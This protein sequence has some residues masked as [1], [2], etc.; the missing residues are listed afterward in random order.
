MCDIYWSFF[1]FFLKKKSVFDSMGRQKKQARRGVTYKLV[2]LPRGDDDIVF[3]EE[4]ERTEFVVTSAD[5]DPVKTELVPEAALRS[6]TYHVERANVR[7]NQFSSSPRKCAAEENHWNNEGER[8]EEEMEKWEREGRSTKVMKKDE[9]EEREGEWESAKQDDGRGMIKGK[10]YDSDGLQDGNVFGCPVDTHPSGRRSKDPNL[11]STHPGRKEDNDIL[12]G[13]ED[14][15]DEPLFENAVEGGVTDDFLRQ[16]VLG[17]ERRGRGGGGE[18][19]HHHHPFSLSPDDE[20]RYSEGDWDEG[21]GEEYDEEE[22]G[23]EEDDEMDWDAAPLD[24]E[25]EGE[26][27]EQKMPPGMDGEVWRLLSEEEREGIL[28][29]DPFHSIQRKMGARGDS[30]L[31]SPPT[32]SHPMRSEKH[33][34]RHETRSRL[35]DRQFTEMLHEFHVDSAINDV[36]NVNDPRTQGPLSV[37][38]YL[39]ALQ[40]FVAERAGLNF[41]TAELAKNKGLMQ[42]LRLLQHREGAFGIDFRDGGIYMPSV[43]SQK[44]TNFAE[45][46]ADETEAIRAAAA[47]R[48]KKTKHVLSTRKEELSSHVLSIAGQESVSDPIVLHETSADRSEMIHIDTDHHNTMPENAGFEVVTLRPREKGKRQD[49]ETVL[50]TYSAYYNQPNV[51]RPSTSR[52]RLTNAPAV[53]TENGQSSKDVAKSRCY[54]NSIDSCSSGSAVAPTPMKSDHYSPLE[55]ASQLEQ[56]EAGSKEERNLRKKIFKAQQRQRRQEKSDLKKAYKNVESEEL[57]RISMSTNA[58]KTVHFS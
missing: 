8:E 16:L 35:I 52:S 21:M 32:H 4:E 48:V 22:W 31:P 11:E 41:E 5:T 20:E 43:R 26:K 13:E 55:L 56:V 1:F 7:R 24:E 47:A 18:C 54:P 50:S 39:P 27:R 6:H 9:M 30:F 57:K 45:S 38:Q 37:H 2:Q 51:I 58:K 12:T 23:V 14:E 3:D 33:Y 40:E 15:E 29:A 46:F 10:T 34:P 42:Q 36:D 28:L 17:T 53:L 25:G 49:C 19:H 44:Q